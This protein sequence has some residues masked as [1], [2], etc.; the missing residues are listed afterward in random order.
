MTTEVTDPFE[1][2]VDSDDEIR[3][4]L[5]SSLARIRALKDQQAEIKKE[6]DA[7]EAPLRAWL[8]EHREPLV[9]LERGITAELHEKRRPAEIDLIS[10]A[11]KPE[12]DTHIA[13]AAGMGLLTARLTPLRAQKGAVECADVLLRYEMP[14]GVTQELRIERYR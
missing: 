5:V 2:M 7:L 13:R 1:G 9:D 6:L 14:G 12:N 10:A 11:Q 4:A 3:A 8:A